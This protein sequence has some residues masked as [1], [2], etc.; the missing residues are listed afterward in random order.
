MF[1]LF[2]SGYI[3]NICKDLSSE[4]HS[5]LYN[6]CQYK[7]KIEDIFYITYSGGDDLFIVGP[8]SQV[9]KLSSAINHEFRNFTCENPN[10]TLSSGIFLCKPKF[11]VNRFAPLAGE[12]LKKSKNEGRNRNSVF[13]DTVLWEKENNC[14]SFREL[15]GFGET[16][17]TAINSK[18]TKNRLPTRFVYR[19]L[20]L[21]N[22]RFRD[23]TQ[24]IDLRY[25]PE[26]IYNIERNVS[27][28]ISIETERGIEDL[29]I[30]L[31][32]KLFS[33]LE[34]Q[35]LMEK[36]RIPSSYA[37]LKSRKEG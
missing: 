30:Y 29:K 31:K 34:S 32:K 33:N 24:E 7:D 1:D 25:I 36:I 9:I 18:D 19:L 14:P 5:D 37:L 20:E 17:F 8:W 26:L 6:D 28:N 2:F 3:N 11:P 4:W 27:Q 13:G 10:I 21:R 22:K 15:L 23:E 12:V 35:K 16:L